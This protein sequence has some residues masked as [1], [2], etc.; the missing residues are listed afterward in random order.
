[1][2]GQTFELVEGP[3]DACKS[4]LSGLPGVFYK[5]E[6]GRGTFRLRGEARI[7]GENESKD[8]T[9][10]FA[11][12]RPEL[13]EVIVDQLFNRRFPL[14]EEE[15]CNIS[16]PGNSWWAMLEDA[17]IYVFLGGHYSDE[18]ISLGPIGD[19]AVAY[20]LFKRGESWLRRLLP[21]EEFSLTPKC[22][23]LSA[24]DREHAIFQQFCNIFLH[25]REPIHSSFG[26]SALSLY[27][28]E[29][30]IVRRFW[31]HLQEKVLGKGRAEL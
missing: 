19:A 20:A 18:K 28:D 26:T 13:A 23:A 12:S 14:E 3:E 17:R 15:L 10:F 16:D 21:I 7:H 5:I 1:M 9:R 6:S 30:A 25:G 31:I 4:A 8:E 11:T 2:V 22:F 24:L 27:L 29:L